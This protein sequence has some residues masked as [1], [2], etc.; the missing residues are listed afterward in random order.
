MSNEGNAVAADHAIEQ[1]TTMRDRRSSALG[2]FGPDAVKAS[3]DER[4]AA[5]WREQQSAGDT[6][7]HGANTVALHGLREGLNTGLARDRADYVHVKSDLSDGIDELMSVAENSL[8]QAFSTITTTE[9]DLTRYLQDE[10]VYPAAKFTE[11]AKRLE[12]AGKAVDEHLAAAND[13][14]DTVEAQLVK[15]T[16]PTVV[17]GEEQ[18]ARADARMLLDSATTIDAVQT[19]AYQVISTSDDSVAGMLADD[20]WMS[21]YAASRGFAGDRIPALQ[22]MITDAHVARAE[23]SSD[24]RRRAA[25][26]GL[27][28]VG[29]VRGSRDAVNQARLSIDPRKRR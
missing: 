12:D 24:K 26:T 16:R 29:S 20:T 2:E 5:R 19:R 18:V 3:A 10:T 7:Q 23:S 21:R 4:D 22:K 15:D 14:L 6:S 11:T 13:L 9:N 25:A 28:R 1:D 17:P 27:K 8:H